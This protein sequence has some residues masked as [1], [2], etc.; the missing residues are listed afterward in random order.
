MRGGRWRLYLASGGRKSRFCGEGLLELEK[1]VIVGAADKHDDF[2]AREVE[3]L[4]KNRGYLVVDRLIQAREKVHPSYL[5]GPGKLQE[6]KSKLERYGV[7]VVIFINELRAGQYFR[8]QRELGLDK[9]ILDRVLLILE[10]FESRASTAEAKLQVELARL[11]Y[12]L[13][14]ARELVR[15]KGFDGEKMG[16]GALGSYPYKAYLSFARRRIKLLEEK[17]EKLKIK[18]EM[19]MLRRK[20]IDLPIVTLTGYT[21]S[22]KTSLFNLLACEEKLVGLG[23][24]TTLETYARRVNAYGRSFIV[25]DSLGLVEEMPPLILRAFHATLVEVKLADLLVLLV[26]ASDSSSKIKRKLQSSLSTIASIVENEKPLI[27]AV[28][29]I[30]LVGDVRLE[31]ALKVIKDL[32]PNAEIALI[33]AKKGVNI[34]YLLRKI[35]DNLYPSSSGLKAFT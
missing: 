24:F 35:V 6:L 13:P 28:N 27:I 20:E 22:G 21:Q 5:V 2:K 4:A 3:E 14:W 31:K 8:L 17:L 19:L 12:T 34:G 33:S 1:A 18:E 32:A 16:F 9:K 29:K 7:N 25:V 26:D 11:K 23:P 30:D 10:V 15:L